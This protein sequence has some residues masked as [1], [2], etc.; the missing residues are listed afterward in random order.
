M[1]TEAPRRSRPWLALAVGQIR[2]QLVVLLRTPLGLLLSVAIPLLLLVC[3]NVIIPG[4]PVD[5]LPYA[6]WLTPAMCAFAL[7]NACYTTTVT[8]LVLSREEGI[9][10]RLRGTPVPAS[11][12][13]LGRFG[14][15]LVTSVVACAIIVAVGVG[16]FHVHIPWPGIGYFVLAA[17]LGVGCFFQLGVAV[18]TLVPRAETALPVAFGSML[19]LAFISDVFFAPSHP[20]QW[21]HDLAWSF[22]V[23]PIAVAMEDS[24]R[25]T[26]HSWPM[27]VSGL[28][29]VL[30]WSAAGIATITLAFRWQPG[31]GR[32][33][34]GLNTGH[35]RL[36]HWLRDRR[37][38]RTGS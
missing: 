34:V 29:V 13:L 12:Y 36:R 5:G 17:L 3:L 27:P 38:A 8:S 20:P 4:E 14:S 11:T 31:P 25:P 37:N 7:L 18:T 15:A 19:P 2:Y 1:V 32:A 22:P 16:L 21:L 26:T 24:F 28:L 6:Q 35:H 9:L 23:A 33:T 30:G 10:K